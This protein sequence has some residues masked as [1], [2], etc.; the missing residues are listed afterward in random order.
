VSSP[1]EFGFLSCSLN[2]ARWNPSE[3]PGAETL[4]HSIPLLRDGVGVR[5]EGRGGWST[6]ALLLAKTPKL[7]HAASRSQLPG[8]MGHQ[9]EGEY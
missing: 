6:L 9:L 5:G 4:A 1:G 2:R 3:T 7:L 8:N